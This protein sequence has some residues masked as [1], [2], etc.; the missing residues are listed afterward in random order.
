M[1]V[2]RSHIL[3]GV[4]YRLSL[5]EMRFLLLMLSGMGREDGDFV[6]YRLYLKDLL[7]KFDQPLLHEY[8]RARRITKALMSRVVEIETGEGPL[9]VTFL[10]SVRYF[11]GKGYLEY[12]FDKALKPYLLQ[13]RESFTEYDIRNILPCRSVYSLRMYELLKAQEAQGEWT[14][15]VRSL[16]ER[17]MIGDKY[18]LYGD[19]KRHVLKTARR[20]LE[21]HSDLAFDFQEIRE[22]KRVAK[23]RFLIRKQKQ[24]A[25]A[26]AKG[27]MEE[28]RLPL[29]AWGSGE[30]PVIELVEPLE[31]GRL[32]RTG[33]LGQRSQPVEKP[34]DRTEVSA[35]K[36]GAH[37][38]YIDGVL[39][40]D[41]KAVWVDEFSD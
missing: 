16:K 26:F 12:R 20:E 30:E 3:I 40:K 8:K 4:R 19:L 39:K 33:G 21:Q 22:G 14:V 15:S 2:A 34:P 29:E 24:E 11:K 5:A 9:Q 31:I 27:R 28:E 1:Q 36:E 7:G 18:S 23:L 10:S 38:Q 17:L 35:D 25:F 37:Y 32:P 13:L 41:G 6:T